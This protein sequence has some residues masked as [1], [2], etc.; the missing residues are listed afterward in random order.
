MDGR[1]KGSRAGRKVR[2]RWLL[3]FG[4]FCLW[5]SMAFVGGQLAELCCLQWQVLSCILLYVNAFFDASPEKHTQQQGPLLNS[6]SIPHLA[7]YSAS[8]LTD[9]CCLQWPGKLQ[10]DSPFVAP[11]QGKIWR[12]MLPF[13]L[14]SPFCAQGKIL[15]RKWSLQLDS[16]FCGQCRGLI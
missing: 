6:C 13:Q 4:G 14:D 8:Q 1:K 16:S 3:G 11:P 5:F 2:F 9:L 12:R 15:R 7:S 10:V